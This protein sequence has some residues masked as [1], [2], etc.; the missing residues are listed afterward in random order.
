MLVT[1]CIKH[2]V[3]TIIPIILIQANIEMYNTALD[4]I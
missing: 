3:Y 4:V 2:L 1:H